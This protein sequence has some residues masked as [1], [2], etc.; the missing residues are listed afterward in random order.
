MSP[1]AAAIS[2]APT[3]GARTGAAG[4]LDLAVEAPLVVAPLRSS[5]AVGSA[6]GAPLVVAP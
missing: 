5:D 6:V 3:R 1:R 4:S 2:G